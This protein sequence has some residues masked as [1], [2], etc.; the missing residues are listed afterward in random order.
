MRKHW[1]NLYS[2]AIWSWNGEIPH[3]TENVAFSSQ[4][5]LAGTI[6]PLNCKLCP[7]FYRVFRKNAVRLPKFFH[8]RHPQMLN[9]IVPLLEGTVETLTTKLI[10][11][12]HSL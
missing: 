9:F 2:K 7:Y 8:N 6:V 12:N 10:N 4:H 5:R 11:T 1:R 3:K